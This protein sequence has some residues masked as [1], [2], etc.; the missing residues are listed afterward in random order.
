M[1][2]LIDFSTLGQN[3]PEV[4]EPTTTTSYDDLSDDEKAAL[5]A[6]ADAHPGDATPVRTAYLVF[7]DYDNNVFAT[8]DIDVVL[9]RDHTPSKDEIYGSLA[10]LQKDLASQD[11]A[12]H[13]QIA[14]AQQAQ[15]MQQ[16]MEEARIRQSLA[17]GKGPNGGVSGN[18]ARRR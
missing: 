8:E 16:Q 4:E 7:I 6:H 3:N 10:V 5:D 12:Q 2:D 14:L 13:V 15:A 17:Q 18:P 11:T 1:A 9:D